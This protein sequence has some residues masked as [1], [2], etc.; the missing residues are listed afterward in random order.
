MLFP[1]DNQINCDTIGFRAWVKEGIRALNIE[2]KQGQRTEQPC[3]INQRDVICERKGPSKNVQHGILGCLRL[4]AGLLLLAVAGV[5][6][7]NCHHEF[8]DLHTECYDII[9]EKD[10][11]IGEDRSLQSCCESRDKQTKSEPD[12]FPFN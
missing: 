10:K 2:R 12:N 5:S 11:K 8:L 9:L 4:S 1:F 7:A 3:P 6:D